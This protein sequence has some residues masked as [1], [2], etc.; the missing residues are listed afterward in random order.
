MKKTTVI[1][2]Y[3]PYTPSRRFMSREDYTEI[4]KKKPEKSLLTTLK[5]HS[6]RDMVGRISIRHRG[7]GSKRKF[8]IISSLQ[9]RVNQKAEVVAV[10]YDPNRSARIMLV[11]YLDGKKAYVIAPSNVKVGDSILASEKTQL[12]IGN[13]MKLKNIPVGTEIHNIEMYPES[14]GKLVRSAGS[15][16]FLAA[17]AEGE[18]KRGN[19]V[20]IKMPSG[21]IRLIHKECYASLG[22]VSNI[23]HNTICIGKAGRIRWMGRRSVVRG[24]AQNPDDH[25]HGGG[26]GGS[27]IGMKHPKTPWGKPALGYKTRKNK[28]T[29]RFIIK[30]RK[31]RR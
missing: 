26:E 8:R 22:R 25:P 2:T 10:E 7:G 5:K 24:K 1:K 30:Q 15:V 21:E 28:R 12:K 4:T 3:K 16:A 20:Q 6:G 31:N 19:Y 17:Y 23:S 11:K 13:R 27:P 14:K 29:D 9:E 18:N